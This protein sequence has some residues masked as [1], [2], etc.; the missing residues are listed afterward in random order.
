MDS[1]AIARR[2]ALSV[3]AR[4]SHSSLSSRVMKPIDTQNNNSVGNSGDL[5]GSIMESQSLLLG[6]V[7]CKSGGGLKKPVHQGGK[8][9]E[10]LKLNGKVRTN[11]RTAGPDS[12]GR[13]QSGDGQ[14]TSPSREQQQS[15]SSGDANTGSQGASNRLSQDGD[16]TGAKRYA[17]Y[18]KENG[19]GGWE[20]EG[21]GPNRLPGSSFNGGE[22]KQ[23]KTDEKK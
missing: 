6:P 2:K 21:E 13:Q 14:S 12:P 19:D 3:R 1:Q 4:M 11:T 17:S 5:L 8:V 16:P 22:K 23:K 20:G 10:L 15:G 7:C 18:L 9:S